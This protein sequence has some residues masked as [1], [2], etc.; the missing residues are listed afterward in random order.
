VIV[1]TFVAE[2]T[3]D[4]SVIVSRNEK[5][6]LQS[7]VLRA[8]TVEFGDSTV[9]VEETLTYED[10]VDMTDLQFKPDAQQQPQGG[11][12]FAPQAAPQQPAPAPQAQPQTANPFA[13]QAPAASGQAPQPQQPSAPAPTGNPFAQNQPAPQPQQ[14]TQQQQIEQA[15]AAPPV[16]TPDPAGQPANPFAQGQAAPQPAPATVEHQPAQQP[17]AEVQQPAP[18]A[19]T[20]PQVGAA[21]LAQ[22][23]SEEPSVGQPI[24]AYT[25][26]ATEVVPIHIVVPLEKLDKV[27][28]AIGRAVK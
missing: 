10:T 26:N 7:S 19:D 13:A 23:A 16:P 6:G 28:S 27:L 18:V 8:L 24:A 1:H 14:P 5:D 2:G 11:N 21:P 22:T 17:P 3:V 4:E 20:T 25:P 15:V 12:P 9:T